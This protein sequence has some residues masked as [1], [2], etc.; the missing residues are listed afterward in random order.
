MNRRSF[1]KR[2]GG[3]AAGGALAAAGMALTTP[4]DD[5]HTTA[6]ALRED[7]QEPVM[8]PSVW[9]PHTYTTAST[10]TTTNNTGPWV[11][12]TYDKEQ[13]RW[14]FADPGADA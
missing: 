3:L 6:E 4:D 10:T 2:A 14:L 12:V 1:L 8:V 5:E 7:A 13:G 11:A 9:M